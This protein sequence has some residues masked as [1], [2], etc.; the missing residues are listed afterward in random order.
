MRL[1]FLL[2]ACGLMLTGCGQG[3]NRGEETEQSS[4]SSTIQDTTLDTIPEELLDIDKYQDE[5]DK[6]L[7][8]YLQ[9]PTIDAAVKTLA[10]IGVNRYND[11]S[12][13]LKAKRTPKSTGA[14]RGPNW[15]NDTFGKNEDTIINEFKLL[16]APKTFSVEQI[17]KAYDELVRDFPAD[18]SIKK[19]KFVLVKGLNVNYLHEAP[20][21]KNSIVQLASQFNY[22]ESPGSFKTTVAS[23]LSDHTQ[24]PMGSIEAAAAALHRTAAEDAGKLPHALSRFLPPNHSGYYRNGYLEL[25]K[26]PTTFDT[27]PVY[28]VIRTNLSKLLILPQWVINESSGNQQL[29]V[30]AAAPSF[31]GTSQPQISSDDGQMCVLLVSTQYEAIAKLAVIRS[32]LVIKRPVALHLSLVGQGAYNNPPGVMAHAF[33]K[34]AKAV[35]GFPN[36]HVYVHG[37]G[38]GDQNK[39][40]MQSDP[41]LIDLSKEMDANQFMTA[42]F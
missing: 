34:V 26:I 35:M 1:I 10:S 23:Y 8:S 4:Q 42:T 33:T 11:P 7:L 20:L 14:G 30:F 17:N 25:W 18:T 24:G 40:R 16:E 9:V 28:D 22:L 2:V 12:T 38:A 13:G 5:Q 29:Q 39:I 15:I 31:Q 37:Y 27:H 41:N 6:A 32:L 36:V 19:A 21:G 3:G